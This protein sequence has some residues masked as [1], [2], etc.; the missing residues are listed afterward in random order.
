MKTNLRVLKVNVEYEEQ[1][2]QNRSVLKERDI[3]DDY[4]AVDIRRS[5]SVILKRAQEKQDCTLVPDPILA[6]K[7]LWYFQE[8][9]FVQSQNCMSR[10]NK[11]SLSHINLLIF[12]QL[13]SNSSQFNDQ[14]YWSTAVLRRH[15]WVIGDYCH[16]PIVFFCLS[17]MQQDLQRWRPEKSPAI[18]RTLSAALRKES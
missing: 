6:W 15:T 18:R 2:T 1:M 11:S 14:L 4:K 3:Y 5:D 12:Q 16:R 10:K 8:G 17:H 9:L 13:K 7:C